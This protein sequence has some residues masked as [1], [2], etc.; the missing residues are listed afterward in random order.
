MNGRIQKRY[1]I[2]FDSGGICNKY[3]R[4]RWSLKENILSLSEG[5]CEYDAILSFTLQFSA[6][7]K[8]PYPLARQQRTELHWLVFE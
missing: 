1:F 7:F 4:R 6:Y 2:L 3:F 8:F 5:N